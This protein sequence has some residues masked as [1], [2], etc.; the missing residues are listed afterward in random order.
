MEEF[1]LISR[2]DG[3]GVCSSPNIDIFNY[4]IQ[5]EIFLKMQSSPKVIDARK[6]REV[7]RSCNRKDKFAIKVYEFSVDVCIKYQDHNELFKA[8]SILI[9]DLYIFV[10]NDGDRRTE[11]SLYYLL[12]LQQN[13]E[14]AE[15]IAACKNIMKLGVD[16][17]QVKALEWYRYSTMIDYIQLG[18]MYTEF[19]QSER[20]LL[21]GSLS[22]IRKRIF[23]MLKKSY[24]QLPC[25]LLKEY[26]LLGIDEDWLEF[27]TEIGLEI[28]Q[29]TVLLKKL[30]VK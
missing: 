13:V 30:K 2:S 11:M 4:E 21:S 19:S 6:L 10:V 8:L 9:K 18:R 20:F 22:T 3:S 1:E 14:M 17:D 7:I 16:L 28:D 23:N 24:F 29:G 12:V 25:C 26:L 15:M 27:V 5:E